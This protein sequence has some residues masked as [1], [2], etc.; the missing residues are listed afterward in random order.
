[1]LQQQNGIEDVYGA[2]AHH[3]AESQL[4]LRRGYEPDNDLQVD[5]G[6][7]DVHIPVAVEV[8]TGNSEDGR[9]PHT[10]DEPAL[11]RETS[12]RELPALV[13]L[14]NDAGK[15]EFAT[16]ARPASAVHAKPRHTERHN[17]AQISQTFADMA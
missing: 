11:H 7:E 14:A 1:M 4:S 2:V 16:Y 15:G 6:V 10:R 13:R 8:A 17:T 12:A 3:V 9:N 5:D